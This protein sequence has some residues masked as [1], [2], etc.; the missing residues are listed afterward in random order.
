MGLDQEGQYYLSDSAFRSCRADINVQFKEYMDRHRAQ[1]KG[2][3]TFNILQMSRA[4]RAGH[5][6][7]KKDPLAEFSEKDLKAGNLMLG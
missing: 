4:E 6:F 2:K 7:D 3:F 5:A 1:P